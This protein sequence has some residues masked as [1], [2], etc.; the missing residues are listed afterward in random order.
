MD[1][2]RYSLPNAA[3]KGR[4]AT[5]G[6]EKG[7]LMGAPFDIG[8]GAGQLTSIEEISPSSWPRVRALLV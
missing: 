6:Q 5:A 8:T 2:E 3:D 4:A 7:A 1:D